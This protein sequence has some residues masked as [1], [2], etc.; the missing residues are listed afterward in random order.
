MDEIKGSEHAPASPPEKQG[1]E[2]REGSHPIELLAA[3]RDSAEYPSGYRRYAI[4]FI[5]GFSVVLPMLV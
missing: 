4:G 1:A 2:E 3:D 5:L